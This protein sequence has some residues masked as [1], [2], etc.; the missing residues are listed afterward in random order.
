MTALMRLL[1]LIL[2]LLLAACGGGSSAPPP[3]PVQ[4]KPVAVSSDNSANLKRARELYDKAQEH[5]TRGD[6]VGAVPLLEQA[7][8]LAPGDWEVQA[9]LGHAY[10]RV[11]RFA[12]ARAQFMLAA[13]L[14]EGDER[15]ELEG[16]AAHC[17]HVLADEAYKRGEDKLALEH[18]RDAVKLRPAEAEISMLLGYVQQRRKEYAEAESAFRLAADLFTDARRR[19]AM[20]WLGQAQFA[21]EKYE[22]TLETY[23]TLINERVTGNDIYGWRAYCH[24]LLGNREDARR[25]FERAVEYATTPEKRKEYGDAAAALAQ[26]GD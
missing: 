2:L 9:R 3:Q 20:F 24:H 23:T 10:E 8:E 25:D 6:Y 22:E 13:K 7:C 19:D 12:E 1:A 11:R 21:Q 14:A 17:S 15:V 18:L 5:F 4:N 26:E 16:R